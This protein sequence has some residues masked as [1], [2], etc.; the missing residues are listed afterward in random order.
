M[1]LQDMTQH[2]PQQPQQQ[3]RRQPQQQACKQ[4][5]H[6]R[7][8]P[9]CNSPSAF[10]A[11]PPPSAPAED[12]DEKVLEEEEHN[13]G[14][15]GMRRS[16]R[17]WRP[18]ERC[19]QPLDRQSQP[20]QSKGLQR[21]A[22]YWNGS[23]SSRQIQLPPATQALLAG[24]SNTATPPSDARP[25]NP[26]DGL[27]GGT[28]SSTQ[29]S[30]GSGWAVTTGKLR[31]RNP[32][33]GMLKGGG[34][35]AGSSVRA[36]PA[37]AGGHPRQAQALHRLNSSSAR[38][39]GGAP[40]GLATPQLPFVASQQQPQPLL[41]QQGVQ[42]DAAALATSDPACGLQWLLGAN[43]AGRCRQP[44]A[45]SH[46][47]QASWQQRRGLQIVHVPS[48]GIDPEGA[49][50]EAAEQ[51]QAQWAKPPQLVPGD[52]SPPRIPLPT[53]ELADAVTPGLHRLPGVDMPPMTI[54][55]DRCRLPPSSA[56]P[57]APAAGVAGLSQTP[58]GAACQD[59][60]PG[61]VDASGVSSS[62]GAGLA[63]QRQFI[64]GLAP[65]SRQ[66]GGAAP[67]GRGGGPAGLYGRLQAVLAAEKAAVAQEARRTVAIAAAGGR[68]PRLTVLRK[69]LDGVLTRCLCACDD[70]A[71]AELGLM[72]GSTAAAATAGGAGR[73]GG[74]REVVA[75]LQQRTARE[76]D[77]L[78]GCV[79][80]L[81]RPW[82][83]LD[84]PV[85]PWPVVLCLSV[86]QG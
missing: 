63:L 47:Q 4:Q 77:T 31:R 62:G 66:P 81:R 19:R 65:V 83:R 73:G 37:P 54:S 43:A 5:L 22:V 57:T 55:G 82:Y 70:V 14:M 36:A 74:G 46:Q 60:S 15:G 84:L 11:Y 69:E 27:L 24:G 52:D 28:T 51:Q 2:L 40:A 13:R 76:V 64:Q 59:A 30:S 21:G 39:P 38:T 35:Q 16:G 78:P 45:A 48:E 32:L 85:C 75:F 9:L 68:A 42:A 25:A 72:G 23:G 86:E 6:V 12:D 41:Q 67:R 58:A 50:E 53:Q 10:D 20:E 7:R 26:L 34:S 1:L 17:R 33:Y 71:S 56:R 80:A 18:P 49:E 79:L 61:P 44:S 8:G 3:H 29:S